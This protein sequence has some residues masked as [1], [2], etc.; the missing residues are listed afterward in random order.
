MYTCTCQC[1]GATC[2]AS[3]YNSGCIAIGLNADSHY[4]YSAI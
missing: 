4:I 2:I 3:I 1:S